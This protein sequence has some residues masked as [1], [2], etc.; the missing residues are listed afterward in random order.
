MD[1][2]EPDVVVEVAAVEPLIVETQSANVCVI[3]GSKKFN[4]HRV[5]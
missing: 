3:R 2:A 5:N 4:Y 1:A